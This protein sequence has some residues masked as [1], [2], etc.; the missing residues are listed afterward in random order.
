MQA[1][2]AAAGG[3]LLPIPPVV[4]NPLPQD[5]N[6]ALG[7][8]GFNAAKVDALVAEAFANWVVFQQMK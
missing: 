4:V 2:I 8:C 1:Y 7:L 5:G 6:L 3:N